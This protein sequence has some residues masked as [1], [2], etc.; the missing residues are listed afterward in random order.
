MIKFGRL[1]LDDISLTKEKPIL[2]I[3]P[4]LNILEQLA[5]DFKNSKEKECFLSKVGAIA[6]NRREIT[7][8]LY[9]V[10]VTHK[11][12]DVDDLEVEPCDVVVTNAQ[13]WRNQYT[14]QDGKRDVPVWKDLEKNFFFFF[15]HC[16]R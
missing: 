1:S 13:K 9:L 8:K 3:A 2:V 5:S 16:R 15:C 6:K 12:K 11:R 10:L 4:G 7:N 14:D